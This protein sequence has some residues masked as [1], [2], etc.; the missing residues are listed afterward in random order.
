MRI[1]R[2]ASIVEVAREDAAPHV[3]AAVLMARSIKRGGT[4]LL[5]D[6]SGQ[7]REY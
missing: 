6:P 3:Q 4:V 7:V 2:G 5:R 1:T